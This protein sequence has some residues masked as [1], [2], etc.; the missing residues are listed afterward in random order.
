MT[1]DSSL[2]IV[3]LIENNP[4]TRLSGTYQNKLLTKIKENFTDN[5]QHMFVTSFYCYLNYDYHN[6]F[7][8]DLDKI[9]GWLGFKSKF[10]AK[11]L[12]ENLFTINIDYKKSL[13]PIE[14]QCLHTKGGHNKDIILLNINAFKRFCLKAGT[15]KA[16][17]IHEYFI[18]LEKVLQDVIHQETN[19][20]KLQLD[21]KDRVIQNNEKE[22]FMIREKTLIDQFPKNTQCVYYG[23]IDNHSD[24]NEKLVKF[25]N[26]NHLK[27]RVLQHRDTYDNFR[28]MNAF[29]VVNKLQIET[30]IKEHPFF[31]D[32]IRSINIKNKNLVELLSID[33]ISTSDI[34][35]TIMGIEYSHENYI[36]LLDENRTL[37]QKLFEKQDNDNTH[38]VM[39]LTNDNKRLLLENNKLFRKYNTLLRK[40]GK[41]VL[42]NIADALSYVDEQ[43]CNREPTAIHNQ[44]P[45]ND[46]NIIKLLKR[47]NKNKD[48]KYDVH[49]VIYDNL[50]GSRED[51]WNGLAYKTT[52]ELTKDNLMIGKNGKIVSKKKS[53]QESDYNRFVKTGVNSINDRE[54]DDE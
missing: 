15:K 47:I 28:L 45:V 1:T 14:K 35:K 16:D 20:L 24:T 37:R 19:E 53:I 11:R 13:L 39:V 41:P 2:N 6:D 32:R 3:E 40:S 30:A 8:I 51:V 12:L 42:D 9:W 7:V 44:E 54:P 33:G 10:N 29:K 50:F 22:K 34:D 27:M 46:N 5:E 21:Q 48:G 25:G 23:F 17:E 4:I 49:G 31:K 18:K 38:K 52:G 36:K 43:I 26:S